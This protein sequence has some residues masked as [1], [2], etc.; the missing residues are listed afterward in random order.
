MNTIT[1]AL[2]A[3]AIGP[4]QSFRNISVFPLLQRDAK[5][6]RYITLTE[7]LASGKARIT[8]ISDS[9]SVP[10]LLLDNSSD[11]DVLVLDGE[12]LVGAKQNRI[13]NLTILAAAQAKTVLP[14]SCVEQ[15]RWGYQSRD[16]AASPRAQ[17]SRGRAAKTAAV[18]TSLKTSG[19]YAADQHEVWDA[20]AAKQDRMEV[21]SPTRAMSDMFEQHHDGIEDY[22]SAFIPVDNQVGALF[23]IDGKAKGLD[24]FDAPDTLAKTL[25]K[26]VR[27]FA[28]DALES[29]GSESTVAD[30]ESATQFLD[31]IA[32]AHIDTYSAVGLGKDLRLSAPLVV[33]GGLVHEDRLIH[34]AAFTLDSPT[35][36]PHQTTRG[37]LQS[38]TDR[39]SRMRRS[40]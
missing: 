18:N 21:R 12:E 24:L 20:I 29:A 37:S 38:W 39:F 8:E 22:A 5:P 11:M 2:Q 33:G 26:I 15:G 17:F 6:A 30:R 13:A 34:L 31:R 25:A 27:S 7:A 19:S 23:A 4:A 3:L 36:E 9:G 16:F 35:S 10:E 14:V 32:A 40:H 28:I 1:Y